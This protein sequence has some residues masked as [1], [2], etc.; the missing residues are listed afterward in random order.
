MTPKSYFLDSD[1][2][3]YLLAHAAPV[4]EV[5]QWLIDVTANDL[6]NSVSMQ[7]SPEQ[8]AF[9]TL[10]TQVLNVSQA[11]EVGTFTGYSSLSI[12]RGLAPGGQLICCDISDEFTR[13]AREAWQRARVADRID[14]RIAPALDTLEALPSEPHIDLAFIDAD[15]VNYANYYEALLPRMRPNGVILVDNTLWSGRLTDAT[16]T[17]ADT[18]ALRA[19]NA[20][21]AADERV[22]SLIL[23]IG[24]GLTFIRKR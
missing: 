19:F 7:I 1:T 14:L 18:L 15:K 12:A 21:V 11:V 16:D 9:M 24:D 4:D 10:L 17:S 20:L 3:E 8:G 23:T 13:Y 6:P 2:H 5:Q 22:E